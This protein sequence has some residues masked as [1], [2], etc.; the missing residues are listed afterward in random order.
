MEDFEVNYQAGERLRMAET[1]YRFEDGHFM[2]KYLPVSALIYLPLSYSPLESAK[3]IWYFLSVI[4][5]LLI[6]L[7]SYK[8]L[9]SYKTKPS[10][11]LLLPPLILLKYFQK[12][13]YHGQINTLVTLIVLFLCWALILSESKETKNLEFVAGILGGVAVALKPHA[14]IFFPYFVIKGKWRAVISSTVTMG[15]ALLL[16]SLFYGVKGNF[17]VLQEWYATLSKTT[18]ALYS[19]MNNTSLIGL[20]SKWIGVTPVTFIFYALS[21]GL[22][23]ILVLWLIRYGRDLDKAPLLECAVLLVLIPLVSPLGWEYTLFMSL[24]GIMILIQYFKVFPKFWRVML[25]ITFVLVSL[26]RYDIL[27]RK[28]YSLYMS[29]S[30]TTFLFLIIIGYLSWIRFKGYENDIS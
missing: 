17:M 29:L 9:P 30:V 14:V 20:L 16:P 6:I 23:A 4:W 5:V 12:E 18:P 3:D 19:T 1:L 27:G 28:L 7:I 21:V 2:F 13:M 10:Y 8:L 15:V 25:V 11:L 26:S 24:T 22:L